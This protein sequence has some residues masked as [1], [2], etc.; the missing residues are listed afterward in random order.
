MSMSARSTTSTSKPPCSRARSA[1]QDATVGPKRPLRTLPIRMTSLLFSFMRS[2][3]DD[4]RRREQA[5]VRLAPGGPP[6]GSGLGRPGDGSPEPVGVA[7]CH[8]PPVDVDLVVDQL[9]VLL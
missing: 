7:R 1:T 9:Q 3:I 5:A 6:C 4:R 2:T 8:P